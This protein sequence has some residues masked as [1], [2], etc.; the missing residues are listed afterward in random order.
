MKRNKIRVVPPYVDL[1]RMQCFRKANMACASF[2]Q[3]HRNSSSA[4]T[5]YPA[6]SWDIGMIGV[7][8]IFPFGGLQFYR[9]WQNSK[10]R[11][12]NTTD[13]S[14]TH[15]PSFLPF[16]LLSSKSAR[17]HR[18]KRSARS[19]D[20]R[21]IWSRRSDVRTCRF[22]GPASPN[23]FAKCISFNAPRVPVGAGNSNVSR[24]IDVV[25]LHSEF[26]KP[27]WDLELLEKQVDAPDCIPLRSRQDSSKLVQD[28]RYARRI[29]SDGMR[30]DN[31][32]CLGMWQIETATQG[33]AE[34]VVQC[35][36]N[37]SKAHRA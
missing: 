34:F 7:C 25:F 36:A 13:T 14:Y 35:H 18:A 22:A 30:Q 32:V 9:W 19:V 20:S 12:N 23:C 21:R 27:T 1:G 17:K 5:K 31:G 24:L 26:A 15:C 2:V 10:W 16:R 37:G 28:I 8:E 3:G 29:V 11:K 6:A 4:A 33:V